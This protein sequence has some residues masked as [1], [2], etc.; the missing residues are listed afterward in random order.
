MALIYEYN[1][2]YGEIAFDVDISHSRLSNTRSIN[3]Y[4]LKFYR[5]KSFSM[6]EPTEA[7][8]Q[9]HW[10]FCVPEDTINIAFHDL[11]GAYSMTC[12]GLLIRQAL[13]KHSQVVF[14]ELQ[15]SNKR[16]QPW[17]KNIS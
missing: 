5:E 6:H 16:I 15:R 14:I 11:Y 8:N 3:S 1:T 2:K 7:K 9:G 17:I 4:E 13:Q 10:I 12:D